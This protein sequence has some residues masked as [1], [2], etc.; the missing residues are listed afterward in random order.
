MKINRK[1]ILE[2]VLYDIACISDKEYQRRIW[3]HAE[4]PECG[5]FDEAVCRYSGSAE[6]ILEEYKKYGITETQFSILKKFDEEFRKF[7]IDNDLPQLFI[8]TFEWTMITLMAKQVLQ[9]FGYQK[10]KYITSS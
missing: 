2:G 4:G 10:P 7:W 3:I 5:D 9:A 1:Q 6:S 8:D